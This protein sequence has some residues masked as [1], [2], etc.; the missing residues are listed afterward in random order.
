VKHFSTR[1][2]ARFATSLLAVSLVAGCPAARVDGTWA[3]S[4]AGIY[5]VEHT[6]GVLSTFELPA[7]RG[8]PGRWQAVETLPPSWY[9]GPALY[10][11]D[12]DGDWAQMPASVG[13]TL[14]E[15]LQRHDPPPR[16]AD[17]P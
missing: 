6:D 17:A 8:E 7:Y 13:L 4:P 16:V 5:W 15:V 3:A 1:F 14:D 9:A 2:T 11:L 10:E 12:E